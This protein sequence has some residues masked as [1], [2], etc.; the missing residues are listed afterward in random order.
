MNGAPLGREW[1]AAHLPHQ[2][3]MSLL[4]EITA[5]DRTTLRA[6]ARNHRAAD[7]PLRRGGELPIACGIEYGAQAAAAH[8]ALL[9][10]HPAG[11][12][13]LASARAVEF[14]ARRLDDAAGDLEILA[15]QMG[16]S[17]A[18]V[19]YRFEIASAGRLLVEGRVTVAFPR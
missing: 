18:G 9:S 10:P 17:D 15:E 8:G 1:I 4:D 14:H 11:A 12:G 13:L 6:L 3:R 16:A 19:L 2:G 7:H 5:W